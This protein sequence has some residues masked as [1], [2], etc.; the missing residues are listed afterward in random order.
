M[1][2]GLQKHEHGKPNPE[3]RTNL[4][5][6]SEPEIMRQRYYCSRLCTAPCFHLA[7]C[8]CFAIATDRQAIQSVCVSSSFGFVAATEAAKD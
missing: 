2:S 1:L 7:G 6:E 8:L 4:N 5:L 3:V